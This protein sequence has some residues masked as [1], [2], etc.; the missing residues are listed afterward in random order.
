MPWRLTMNNTVL[1]QPD[2]H[3]F[4]L[5]R[6]RCADTFM[7]LNALVTLL[8]ALLAFALLAHATGIFGRG[9]D[10]RRV[11]T[12]AVPFALSSSRMPRPPLAL[13]GRHNNISTINAVKVRGKDSF[14][15]TTTGAPRPAAR[16]SPRSATIEPGDKG[17]TVV[18][19][20]YPGSDRLHRLVDILAKVASPEWLAVARGGVVLV[21]NGNLEA[22]PQLLIKAIA[23]VPDPSKVR[24]LPQIANRVDNRWRIAANITTDAVLVMDDDINLSLDGAICMWDVWS[25]LRQPGHLVGLD[26]RSHYVVGAP[27]QQGSPRGSAALESK[28]FETDLRNAG[29]TDVRFGY[30]SKARDLSFGFKKYSV[31]LPRAMLVHAQSLDDYST[32]FHDARTQVRDIVDKLRCDDIAFNFV[33]ANASRRR[34]QRGEGDV[35]R[36]TTSGIA[37]N[38]RGT[39]S[40]DGWV[41]SPPA[42][43][44]YV[45]AK[46][47]VYPESHTGNA[48]H[49]EA[50]MKDNRQQC[51]NRLAS[52][53]G[54]PSWRSWHVVCSVDG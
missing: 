38:K 20:S 5:W 32:A 8:A 26:V 2:Y 30:A 31:V 13:V 47:E 49:R 50:K 19:M 40:H 34:W 14:S 3:S 16:A 54:V 42:N 23:G 22:L 6:V 21:W 25:S 36:T 27:K 18:L 29:P 44:V 52:T 46:Y 39:P 45:K 41:S 28:R 9:L 7:R 51:V 24:V 33:A 48:M 37:D 35:V 4:F 53:L 17:L 15:E 43:I 10:P 11:V 12:S 1:Y